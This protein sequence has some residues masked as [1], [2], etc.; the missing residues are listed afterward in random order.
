M[1]RRR[2]WAR[3]EDVH[4]TTRI[5]VGAFAKGILWSGLQGAVD[6]VPEEFGEEDAPDAGP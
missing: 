6:K 3:V 1:A 4:D 5:R 2:G